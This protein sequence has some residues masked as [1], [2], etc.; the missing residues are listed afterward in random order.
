MAQVRNLDVRHSAGETAACADRRRV[1]RGR[2]DRRRRADVRRAWRTAGPDG[3]GCL[4][5]GAGRARPPAAAI[6]DLSD[7]RRPAD[8]RPELG[9][10]VV[11]NGCIYN[12]RELRA[13]LS[14]AG[15]RFF[16]TSDTEVILKAYHRWGDGLRRALLR[17][18]SPSPSS[19][20]TPAGWCWPATGS[21]SSRSTSPRRRAG[22]GSPRPCRRCSPAA[23]ST[24]TIDPVALHHYMT[25]PLRGARRRARSSPASASCRRP[26]CGSIEPD[27]REHRH[28]V[29]GAGVQPRP[30]AAATVRAT[31]GRSGSWRA[32]RIA[33]ERRMV[34]DV[35]VGVLLSG[36]LDSSLIVALLAEAG[37]DRPDHV[38]HR[39]RVGGGESGDEFEYSDLVAE[40]FGTDHHQIRI[41][42]AA[43]AARRAT[44]ADRRDER[45][46]GQPR[47]RRL[48]PALRG[49]LEA[50]QGGAVR[51]GRRRGARRLRLVPAAGRRA[52]RRTPSRRTRGCSSTAAHDALGG[53]LEPEWLLD[54]R[55]QPRRSSPRTSAAP[56]ADTAVDAA[57]RIDTT[58]M[59]VDDPVKRVDNMT[60]AWGLEAR[61][62]FLDHE[63]VELAGRLPAGAEAG[64]RRQGRAQG[65][66]AAASSRTR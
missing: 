28:R 11:F 22:C 50:R 20:A 16:S 64:R 52:P 29:L 30:P 3:C 18:C 47:L 12:Y 4:A 23:T 21:A 17:A 40:H 15:Y 54:R 7:A 46:D 59:L 37:P 49:G 63:L 1:R 26:P 39:L 58:V 56:G 66:A 10:T 55:R 35:P 57:L 31:T 44:R 14:A 8:G 41:G 24:P 42:S 13:E 62:P 60:M 53:L 45:A 51:A 2:S 25:L 9:L 33:V 6:I 43:A 19:S 27:G 38:Q 61:V 32:L 34:A 5:A 48:L 65:G 36:G